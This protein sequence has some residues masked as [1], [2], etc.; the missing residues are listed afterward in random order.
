MQRRLFLQIPAALGASSMA[1]DA[2]HANYLNFK[3]MAAMNRENTPF[4]KPS[5]KESF[6]MLTA[7]TSHYS[8]EP[9]SVVDVN[10]INL[11]SDGRKML[12]M[13]MEM[14]ERDLPNSRVLVLSDC[15]L[16]KDFYLEPWLDNL[17]VT[18]IYCKGSMVVVG[19]FWNDRID[20]HP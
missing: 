18:I 5:E 13:A 16:T 19:I 10:K 9:C 4:S 1:L 11:P 7:S 6:K 15:K 3:K 12:N 2:A 20:F 14:M 17:G 8:L